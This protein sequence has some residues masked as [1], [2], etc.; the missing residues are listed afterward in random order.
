MLLSQSFPLETGIKF[1]VSLKLTFSFLQHEIAQYATSANILI[2]N[3][4]S[5]A[6]SVK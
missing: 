4:V 2:M 6:T 3:A 5:N 1:Q